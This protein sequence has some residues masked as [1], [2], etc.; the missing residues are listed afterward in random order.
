MGRAIMKNH[1]LIVT[2][3]ILMFIS[4]ALSA[5]AESADEW[6]YGLYEDGK[7]VVYC[8]VEQVNKV[9]RIECVIQQYGLRKV[10]DRTTEILYQIKIP[11]LL[12]PLAYYLHLNF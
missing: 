4:A 6:T 7:R 8:K 12:D 9:C 2:L 11:A 1:I 5:Y 10:V 3:S